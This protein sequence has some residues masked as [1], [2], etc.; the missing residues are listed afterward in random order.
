MTQC[1]D[2]ETYVTETN[3]KQLSAKIYTS[4]RLSAVCLIY[5]ALTA[6]RLWFVFPT[7]IDLVPSAATIRAHDINV[8]IGTT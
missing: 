1:F 8:T 3:L 5:E 2:T 6:N 4:S 7:H